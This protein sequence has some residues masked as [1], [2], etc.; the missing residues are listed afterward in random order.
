MRENEIGLRGEKARS[1]FS[2]KCEFEATATRLEISFDHT[3]SEDGDKFRGENC[4]S[5]VINF[6]L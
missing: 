5:S 1:L 4:K 6:L 2:A 3:F